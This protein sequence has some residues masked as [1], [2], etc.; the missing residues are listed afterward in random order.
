VWELPVLGE[1]AAPPA[2]VIRPDG[3]VVWGRRPHGPRAAASTCD[4]VR[5]GHSGLEPDSRA[6]SRM[7]RSG[8]PA[9]WPDLWRCCRPDLGA[10]GRTE[11][12]D[13][14]RFRTQGL[15]AV[16]RVASGFVASD[17]PAPRLRGSRGWEVCRARAGCSWPVRARVVD[18]RRPPRSSRLRAAGDRRRAVSSPATRPTRQFRCP[19]RCLTRRPLALDPRWG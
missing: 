7:C 18:R 5:S 4:L 15:S 3:H 2:V 17:G 19:P 10:A 1:I 6:P 14:R 9:L 8:T 13:R 16:Q 11:Q 12:P